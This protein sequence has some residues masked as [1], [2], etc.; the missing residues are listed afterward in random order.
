M[1]DSVRRQQSIYE[2]LPPRV[3]VS[4]IEAAPVVDSVVKSTAE[5]LDVH[6]SWKLVYVEVCE[7]A[8]D[9]VRIGYAETFCAEAGLFGGAVV[10]VAQ[11]RDVRATAWTASDRRAEA[12]AEDCG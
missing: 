10:V 9:I 11:M 6:D 5:I 2:G 8:T 7:E 12:R 1:P 4:V 3:Q